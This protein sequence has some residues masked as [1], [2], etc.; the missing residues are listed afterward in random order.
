MRKKIGRLFLLIGLLVSL[1]MTAYAETSYGNSDWSVAFTKDKK[2]E[3]NFKTSDIDDVIYGL[4]PGDNVIINL[5]LKNENGSATDWYM[6]GTVRRARAVQTGDVLSLTPFIITACVT[7]TL[8]M[9]FAVCSQRQREK[10]K[11]LRA[12]RRAAQ[13]DE[14]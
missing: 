1:N 11:K 6:T 3:T 4:Q 7:G 2:M 13:H 5:K 8:L 9:I 12:K 14:F 10:E